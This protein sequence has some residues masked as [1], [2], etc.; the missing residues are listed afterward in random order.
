M[1]AQQV[2]DVKTGAVILVDEGEAKAGLASGIYEP[3]GK[4]VATTKTGDEYAVEAADVGTLGLTEAGP[5]AAALAAQQAADVER[6]GDSGLSA[7]A[8][9]VGL[10]ASLGLSALGGTREDRAERGRLVRTN[11]GSTM[12]GQL[13]GDLVLGA[14]TSAPGALGKVASLL[15]G[16]AVTRAS[17]RLVA[18]GLAG[19]R[20]AGAVAGG[21]LEGAAGAAADYLA[22]QA[23]SD[24]PEL[25]GEAFAAH[26]GV[27]SLLGGAIG[28]GFGAVGGALER[29]AGRRQAGALADEA[30]DTAL[31]VARAAMGAVDE[32]AAEADR[33]PLA[34]LVPPRA[35]T[36]E[37]VA[38]RVSGVYGALRQAEA[39]RVALQREI[40]DTVMPGLD[41]LEP[42]QA[43]A[44][45]AEL[46]QATKAYKS[47]LDDAKGWARGID[48]EQR[49][50]A[51]VRLD[52]E[53]IAQAQA[54]T[55]GIEGTIGQRLER[56]NLRTRM[57]EARTRGVEETV[58]Q[59][60]ERER[61]RTQRVAEGPRSRKR[62][63]D[64]T[65]DVPATAIPEAAPG[66]DLLAQ[67]QRTQEQLGAGRVLGEVSAEGAA[68]VPKRAPRGRQPKMPAGFEIGPHI[69]PTARRIKG[70]PDLPELDEDALYVVKASDLRARGQRGL[71]DGV[72]DGRKASIQRGW[73][74]GKSFEPIDVTIARNGEVTVSEGRARLLAA[75]EEGRD[76]PVRFS[77]GIEEPTK[78]GKE[79]VAEWLAKYKRDT[80]VRYVD[81]ATG[82]PSRG[83]QPRAV[84]KVV[85]FKGQAIPDDLPAPI[86]IASF[87]G[88]AA[89]E[90]AERMAAS[91]ALDP[92]IE[93]P[94]A[95]AQERATLGGMPDEIEL[96]DPGTAQVGRVLDGDS[97]DAVEVFAKLDEAAEAMRRAVATARSGQPPQGM[98]AVSLPDAPAGQPGLAR[99]V[100]G[101]AQNLGS[102]LEVA[103][104]LGVPVP[105]A[106]QIPVV[107][108]ALS[109]YLKLR[110]AW[111]ALR[112]SG[113]MLPATAS[114]RAA[115][116][117]VRME[118]GARAAADRVLE[119]GDKALRSSLLPG[120]A[121][122]QG[123]RL[124]ARLIDGE[125]E[126]REI[127]AEVDEVMSADPAS[128]QIEIARSA[129]G[130]PLPVTAG[131]QEAAARAVAY[132]QEV[133]PK[134]AGY[135]TPWAQRERYSAT[136]I[137]K[138]RQ[139]STAVRQPEATA[140][141]L[142]GG[143][144]APWAREAMVRVW[145][146]IWAL[147]REEL[148]RQQ[149]VLAKL[150]RPQRM[151][152]GRN[153]DLVLDPSRIPGYLTAAS[154]PASTQGGSGS[155]APTRSAQ[156]SSKP[157][158]AELMATPEQAT[159]IQ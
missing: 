31:D 91:R 101:V 7:F 11:P 121:A 12:A 37:G 23:L 72:Q 108:P 56:E 51:R 58:A 22:Q 66:D 83:I 29:R 128:L 25:S 135:G 49:T 147:Y 24:R 20:V 106:G 119:L 60:L 63:A 14:A 126:Q 92:D 122:R 9:G 120:M 96:V 75:A 131:A 100:A 89:G 117:K 32:L 118:A 113:T 95:L 71:T 16:G 90:R 80:G 86:D 98:G 109:S 19:S 27:G 54:R 156:P 114:A 134:P 155:A 42:E 154:V 116:A 102:A 70:I 2:R 105:S 52:E 79:A 39:E 33:V 76:I 144:V 73:K 47:A 41:L 46:G 149:D 36:P 85:S 148:G 81:S 13:A 6:Y 139:R 69:S 145:P 125:A 44:V 93:I 5:E 132:L 40:D 115:S 137:A 64:A 4:V 3:A 21:A 111:R 157:R 94:A 136:E 112:G 104:A 8:T 150:S 62:A 143:L 103:N 87:R 55:S 146:Q 61:L 35:A 151:A 38:E 74:D 138:W 123:G 10:S 45:R 97:D 43:K 152:I 28:G 77:R 130:A 99:K 110:A 88:L 68:A 48:R 57:V 127:Q 129:S 158:I 78:R 133:A 53:R 30:A 124:A 67:L 34:S 1:P 15:P 82:A 65:P 141:A 84:D 59:R 107:G 142:A 50:M 140:A 153:F 26:L 17:E 18:G 159:V